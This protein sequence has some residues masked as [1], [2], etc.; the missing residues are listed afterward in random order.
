[1]GG[2]GGEKGEG[3]YVNM[4][5]VGDY[6][7]SCILFGVAIQHH[8]TLSQRLCYFYNLCATKDVS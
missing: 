7:G 8:R 1:M 5:V 4:Y 3:G 6:C 2:G